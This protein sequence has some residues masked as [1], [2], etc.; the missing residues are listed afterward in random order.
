MASYNVPIT[1]REIL[2]VLDH[3]KNSATG[4]DKVHYFMLKHLSDINLDYL[5]KFYNIIFLKHYFPN[6]WK[7]ALIIPILKPNKDPED[8]KSY[9]P[10]SLLSCIFKILDKIINSRLM[11]FLEKKYPFE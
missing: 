2:T 10:I 7:R 9:R 8:P 11:W 3:C 5:K 6:S 1:K 4:D